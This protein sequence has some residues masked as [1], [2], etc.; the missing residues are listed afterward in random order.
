MKLPNSKSMM[1]VALGYLCIGAAVSL[2]Q[3]IF[4]ALTVFA[5]TGSIT[6]NLTLFFWWLIVPMLIWPWDLFWSLFHLGNR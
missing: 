2:C 4:G 1:R 3:N 5:W 6:G